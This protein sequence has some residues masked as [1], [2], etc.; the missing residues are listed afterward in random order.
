MP[1]GDLKAESKAL[2]I[3]ALNTANMTVAGLVGSM[4]ETWSVAITEPL[5]RETS[6]TDDVGIFMADAVRAFRSETNFM[7]RSGFPVMD[8]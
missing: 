2:G 5:A 7:Y 4:T 8:I 6:F 1:R 3:L